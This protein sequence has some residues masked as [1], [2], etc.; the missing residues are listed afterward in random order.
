MSAILRVHNPDVLLDWN[1]VLSGNMIDDV[2]G[3]SWSKTGTITR[4][5]GPMLGGSSGAFTGS[6]AITM[7]NVQ[8]SS[9][10]TAITFCRC[11]TRT[12]WQKLWEFAIGNVYSDYISVS[13]LQPPYFGFGP[14]SIGAHLTPPNDTEARAFAMVYDW[15]GSAHMLTWIKRGRQFEMWVGE[16][17][18][19]SVACEESSNN[20]RRLMIGNEY[21]FGSTTGWR[22]GIGGFGLWRRAMPPAELSEIFNTARPS[23]LAVPASK[24]SQ[25]YPS[26]V[27]DRCRLILPGMARIDGTA[28]QGSIAGTVKINN[29]PVSRIVRCTDHLTATLVAETWSDP[30]TGA[31][32]FDGLALDR[33]FY[34]LS[35]DHEREYN[36]AVADY[37]Y[38]EIIP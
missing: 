25:F 14:T 30:V 8:W 2:S 26:I 9:D 19:S 22:G 12:S 28:G 32:R 3:L 7:N 27:F 13:T 5:A 35:H 11:D 31:Y 29:R 16:Q 15:S 10:W 4:D 6:Q 24:A 34:L 37:R 18:V 21:T 20:L 36:A 23:G 33:L 1:R 38:A 17:H